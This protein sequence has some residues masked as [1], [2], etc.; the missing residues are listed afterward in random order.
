M[1][2]SAMAVPSVVMRDASHGG[3]RPPWSGR[4]AMPERFT[5]SFSHPSR[6]PVAAGV[7]IGFRRLLVRLHAKR[8][9]DAFADGRARLGYAV[10]IVDLR[11]IVHDEKASRLQ[12]HVYGTAWCRLRPNRHP[13][14]R[15]Q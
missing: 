3:T 15:A 13:P 8:Q 14:R 5:R 1:T 11:R 2:L 12:I 4:S 6:L 7:L 10:G 9:T